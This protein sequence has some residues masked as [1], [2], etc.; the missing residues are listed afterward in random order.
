M[1]DEARHLR[2][3][4]ARCRR[5]ALR[6]SRARKAG[7]SDRLLRRAGELDGLADATGHPEPSAAPVHPF[8]G[9]APSPGDAQGA[10]TLG[11]EP[12]KTA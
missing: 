4:A 6:A 2:E 5:L 9:R 11:D 1:S 8:L 7:L 12:E 3:K 10:A